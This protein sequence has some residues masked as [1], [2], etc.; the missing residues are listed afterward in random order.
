MG[1]DMHNVERKGAGEPLHPFIRVFRQGI[2]AALGQADL[3]EEL[4]GG[5]VCSGGEGR[6]G[7]CLRK[8]ARRG[9]PGGPRLG[10]ACC[11]Q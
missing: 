4:V 5:P 7:G 11:R 3:K 1:T 8:E 2:M 9:P 10:E 6:A